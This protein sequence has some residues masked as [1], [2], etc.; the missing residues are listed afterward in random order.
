MEINKDLIPWSNMDN[1]NDNNVKVEKVSVTYYQPG[2]C[3]QSEDEYQ[4]IT[5]T[6]E[7]GGGGPFIRISIPDNGIWSIT[8]ETEL[9][10]LIK[11]FQTRVNYDEG[12]WERKKREESRD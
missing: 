8:D 10:K 7:D 12:E 11:D 1:Y 6:T 3:C 4:Y 2:D 5:L 9:V